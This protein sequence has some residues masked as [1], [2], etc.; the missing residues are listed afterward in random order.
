MKKRKRK[1]RRM[2]RPKAPPIVLEVPLPVA[3]KP[4]QIAVEVVG[5]K[6]LIRIM[7]WLKSGRL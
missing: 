1:P 2:P 5:K 4:E 7:D 6:L 3:V